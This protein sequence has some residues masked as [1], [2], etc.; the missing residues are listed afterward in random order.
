MAAVS[1]AGQENSK[2]Y[3]DMLKGKSGAYQHAY[4]VAARELGIIGIR[5]GELPTSFNEIPFV[6]EI[7]A[8]WVDQNQYADRANKDRW[9]IEGLW[10]DPAQRRDLAS[11]V[12][13][14]VSALGENGQRTM[15]KMALSKV[16][17]ENPGMDLQSD[18]A[19]K[20]AQQ[21]I[22]DWNTQANEE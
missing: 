19:V 11:F 13:K 9:A 1:L 12:I 4:N 16:A 8:Q 10:S 3:G 20:L 7:V 6:M 2:N 15:A 21:Q 14:R 5:A 22:K 17:E 18:Q